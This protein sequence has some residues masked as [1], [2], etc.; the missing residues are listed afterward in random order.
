MV[1]AT[2]KKRKRQRTRH[3][4]EFANNVGAFYNAPCFVPSGLTSILTSAL[5]SGRQRLVI[6]KND[7]KPRPQTRVFGSECRCL[8]PRAGKVTKAVVQFLISLKGN[9]RE[10]DFRAVYDV[11]NNLFEIVLFFLVVEF[12]NKES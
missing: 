5:D 6:A 3:L 11:V 10:R 8:T 7:G 9:Y 2:A 12:L 1:T 4:K